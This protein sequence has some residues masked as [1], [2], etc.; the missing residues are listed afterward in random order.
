MAAEVLGLAS[1]LSGVT[2][3]QRPDPSCIDRL[4][5]NRLSVISTLYQP[6]VAVCTHFLPS[7]MISSL[8]GEAR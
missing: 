7:G 6:D 4:N 8:K 5:A 1:R 3:E 2:R